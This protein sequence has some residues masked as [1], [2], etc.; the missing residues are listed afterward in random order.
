MTSEIELVWAP[1]SCDATL[2]PLASAVENAA[3]GVAYERAPAGTA[4]RAALA[5]RAAVR[6]ADM[7]ALHRSQLPW[8]GLVTGNR[9]SREGSSSE[10]GQQRPPSPSHARR[11]LPHFSLALCA[12]VLVHLLEDTLKLPLAHVVL[13]RDPRLTSRSC[14]LAAIRLA[15]LKSTRAVPVRGYL[16]R[17]LALYSSTLV[18][19]KGAELETRSEQAPNSWW[20]PGK[21]NLAAAAPD[22]CEEQ[23][24]IPVFLLLRA[25]PVLIFVLGGLR[26]GFVLF[27][28]RAAAVLVPERVEPFSALVD[29]FPASE[30]DLV[31]AEDSSSDSAQFADPA[32]EVLEPVPR[33]RRRRERRQ[34][35]DRPRLLRDE[36]HRRRVPRVGQA[37][38]RGV[39]R[40]RC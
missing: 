5:R 14:S 2:M 7:L 27:V 17:F 1:S 32:R 15:P 3:D 36:R 9:G 16:R 20:L 18:V 28:R 39:G 13:P 37:E 33:A 6:R 8:V 21:V 30:R 22:L 38:Q 10:S 34:D 31:L 26:R 19:Q 12:H 35:R 24:Q 11:R 29:P 25:I 40:L 23:L 4:A